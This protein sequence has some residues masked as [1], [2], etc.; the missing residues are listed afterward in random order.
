M[1]TNLTDQ[2]KVLA[3]FFT[4]YRF[5]PD[6]VDFV[7]YNDLGLP[8]AYLV[9]SGLVVQI[10]EDGAKLISETFNMLVTIVGAEPNGNYQ[11]LDGLFDAGDLM[12]PSADGS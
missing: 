7:T 11:T 8:L 12:T 9:A 4:D 1:P 6:W 3:E 5:E 10:T 2:A